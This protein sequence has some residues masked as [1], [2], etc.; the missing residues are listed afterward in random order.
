M[1]DSV[2]SGSP[3]IERVWVGDSVVV[4]DIGHRSDP[5]LGPDLVFTIVGDECTIRLQGPVT[6]RTVYPHRRDAHYVGV[7][8]RPGVGISSG[9]ASVAELRDGSIAVSSVAG[10]D[11]RPIAERLVARRRLVD[12]GEVVRR[13]VHDAA[14][15][16]QYRSPLVAAALELFT[17]SSTRARVGAV[18]AELGVS[19]R[20]LQRHFH[21]HLGVPPKQA[22]RVIRV[23]RLRSEIDRQR[24]RCDD[25]AALAVAAGFYDQSHMTN[26]VGRVLGITPQRLLD[27]RRAGI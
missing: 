9:D 2:L 5:V 3:A 4:P 8:F 11:L 19:E 1:Y 25:L 17:R 10:T 14:L 27:E 21:E 13:A 26:E 18:A 15:S 7:R 20:A 12:R 24:G 22:A 16:S 6:G 23:D